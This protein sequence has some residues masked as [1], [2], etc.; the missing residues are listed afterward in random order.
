[1]SL[2]KGFGEKIDSSTEAKQKETTNWPK[3]DPEGAKNLQ[4]VAEGGPSK[5]SDELVAQQYKEMNDTNTKVYEGGIPA[6]AEVAKGLD[7]QKLAEGSEQQKPTEVAEG[8][9]RQK[10]TEDYFS[11]ENMR[12]KSKHN[13]ELAE[14]LVKK[15]NAS[16][17][18]EKAKLEEEA[19]DCIMRARICDM[20]ADIFS[21]KKK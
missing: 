5:S 7:L 8:S 13:R 6:L 16:Y 4:A 19:I 12:E 20:F 2:F 14:E 11:E 1:M 10:P 9:E 15:A 21:L 17:G 3:Y 18:G